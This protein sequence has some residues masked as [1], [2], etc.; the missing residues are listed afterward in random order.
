MRL[1]DATRQFL[2]RLVHGGS[3]ANRQLSPRLSTPRVGYVA[4]PEQRPHLFRRR[5]VSA[6]FHAGYDRHAAA[7]FGRVSC[8]SRPR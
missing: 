8:P 2:E 5:D 3:P 7:L 6:F 1:A 4:A